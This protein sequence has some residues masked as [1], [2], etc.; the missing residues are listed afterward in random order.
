VFHTWSCLFVP[1][2]SCIPFQHQYLFHSLLHGSLRVGQFTL[3]NLLTT[4]SS[5]LDVLDDRAVLHSTLMQEDA[6]DLGTAGEEEEEV[7]GGKA[8]RWS[9]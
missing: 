6:G 4:L 2:P 8:I 9:V 3:N 5:I 7:N 1:P